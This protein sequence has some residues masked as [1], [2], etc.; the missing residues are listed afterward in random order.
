MNKNT[1]CKYPFNSIAIKDYT[2]NGELKTFW[3]C[4]MMGNQTLEEVKLGISKKYARMGIPSDEK[5]SDYTPLEIFNHPAMENLRQNLI[6]GITNIILNLLGFL[7]AL[8]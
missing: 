1:I 5:L 8:C 7:S 2:N 4:C 3:P 6:N